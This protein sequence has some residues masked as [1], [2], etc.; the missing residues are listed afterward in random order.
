MQFFL[1]KN[2]QTQIKSLTLKYRTHEKI[3]KFI[4]NF[5]GNGAYLEYD[6]LQRNK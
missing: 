3:N 6:E 4:R 1:F 2:F 5:Y